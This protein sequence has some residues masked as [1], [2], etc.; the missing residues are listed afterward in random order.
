MLKQKKKL[1]L[2]T[3]I[4]KPK[5]HIP[6]DKQQVVTE[7]GSLSESQAIETALKFFK[8]NY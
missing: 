8:G 6:Q 5:V 7:T 4:Q 1:E 3:V 2:Q